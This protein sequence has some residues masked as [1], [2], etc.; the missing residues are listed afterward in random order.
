VTQLAERLAP[1]QWHR[2]RVREGARGPL[3]ADFAALRAVAVRD[4]LPGPAVWV[5]L[6]RTVPGE[7]QTGE[8]AEVKYFLSAAPADTP[9]A[10]LV[11]VSGM[12]WPIECCFEAGKGEV[13]LDHYEL[14]FWRG[15]HHQMTLVILAHHFLVRRQQRLDEREGGLAEH[16][17]SSSRGALSGRPA[18]GG[19][20]R[21]A[22]ARPVRPAQSAASAPP[23]G[24]RAAPADPRC[25]GRAGPLG[26]STAAQ[27]GGLL[28][29]ST[30]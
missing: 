25:C 12:R 22:A 11:R 15:W 28:L 27:H 10:E 24:C 13:G 20:G 21:G 30:A 1:T 26:V 19:G 17:T 9:L 16:C 23:A 8:P 2:Y 6:R 5:L 7:E 29:A 3:V 4:G 14:R 18:P